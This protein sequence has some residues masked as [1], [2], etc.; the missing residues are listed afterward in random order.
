M[1]VTTVA[2]AASVPM[3]TTVPAGPGQAAVSVCARPSSGMVRVAVPFVT[4][5]SGATTA[6]AGRVA[7]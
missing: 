4:T 6:R 5:T 3:A 2:P 7:S 1:V